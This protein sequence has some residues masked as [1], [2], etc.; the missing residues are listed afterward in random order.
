MPSKL[1]MWLDELVKLQPK[2]ASGLVVGVRARKPPVW[3]AAIEMNRLHRAGIAEADIVK[4]TGY[5]IHSVKRAIATNG[6]DIRTGPHC[7]A[8][9]G[10]VYTLQE[11]LDQM[12][13]PCSERC[14]CHWSAV[15]A[16]EWSKP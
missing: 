10:R 8:F 2:V 3:E 14:S 13:L 12:P 5:S 15:F 9:I 11:A 1:N 7:D 4:R 16:N 6:E